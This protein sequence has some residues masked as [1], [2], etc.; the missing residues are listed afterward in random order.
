MTCARSERDGDYQG[1]QKKATR[2]REVNRCR[3]ESGECEE[4]VWE[5][6]NKP[7]RAE[8]RDSEN[9][10]GSEQCESFVHPSTMRAMRKSVFLGKSE[11]LA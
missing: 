7:A 2:T 5:E 6:R 8:E 11:N 3:R 9:E 1:E 4:S 10:R